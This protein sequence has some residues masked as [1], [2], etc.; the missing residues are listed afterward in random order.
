[1]K[2][3]SLIIFT[4][5]L[6]FSLITVSFFTKQPAAPISSLPSQSPSQSLQKSSDYTFSNDTFSYTQ[7]RPV[8]LPR[9]QK[10]ELNFSANETFEVYRTSFASRP[11]LNSQTHIAALLFM[12]RAAANA[13]NR[14]FPAIVFLP[15]GGGTKESRAPIAI[16]FAR[17]GYV[18]MVIDQRGIGE[19]A[20]QYLDSQSDYRI[21]A[22]GAE[23]MQHLAV[24][25]AL[26]SFDILRAHPAVNSK[27]IILTGE[28][29]GARYALIAA[30]LDNRI[31]GVL[32]ISAAGFNI[33]PAPEQQ[34][35]NYLRSIDPDNYVARIAPRPLAMLHD[36]NDTVVPL[37]DAQRTFEKAGE[38]KK[39]FTHSGCNH[40]TCPKMN[41]SLE[42][43]LRFIYTFSKEKP[44]ETSTHI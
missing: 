40:G 16:L 23:P 14:S 19:S 5:F 11:L 31:A 42:E 37:A 25:D 32:A 2:V 27:R 8:S 17:A 26:R 44:A 6:L 28:S 21:F 20:G 12:P 10:A 13:T 22:G 41:R 38:P 29:M 1:M 18:T 7:E 9:L 36:P 15:G 24:Y 30:A 3:S 33:P 34:G 43:A 35:N 4:A 39:F